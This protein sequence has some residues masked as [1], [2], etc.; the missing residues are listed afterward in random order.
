MLTNEELMKY[1]GVLGIV[2]Q[3]GDI[4]SVK[5]RDASIAFQRLAKVLHPDK[6]GLVLKRLSKNLEMLMNMFVITLRN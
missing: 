6:E 2:I 4:C 3:I 5:H 1:L